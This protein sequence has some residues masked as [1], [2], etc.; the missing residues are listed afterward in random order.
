MCEDCVKYVVRDRCGVCRIGFCW[1]C[2]TT[3]DCEKMKAKVA[4]REK[5]LKVRKRK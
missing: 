2:L 3:H 5:R 4:E 1:S